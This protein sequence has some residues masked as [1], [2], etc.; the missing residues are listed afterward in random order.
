MIF[1]GWMDNECVR[2]LKEN[3]PHVCI[4]LYN[5]FNQFLQQRLTIYCRKMKFLKEETEIADQSSS[6]CA[7][8]IT[9]VSTI[10]SII[11]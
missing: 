9:A 10:M 1:Q 3:D 11:K 5:G 8:F 2:V 7:T 6:H 4:C